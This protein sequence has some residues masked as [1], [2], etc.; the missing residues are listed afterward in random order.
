MFFRNFIKFAVLILNSQSL[1]GFAIKVKIELYC[2]G[3]AEKLMKPVVE[4]H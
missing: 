3:S 4:K 2:D 1:Q